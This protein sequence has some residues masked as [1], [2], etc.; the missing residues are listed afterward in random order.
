V[1]HAQVLPCRH[2]RAHPCIHPQVLSRFPSITSVAVSLAWNMYSF[3]C[4]RAQVRGEGG[5]WYRNPERRSTYLPRLMYILA[6]SNCP[7]YLI[8]IVH[9]GVCARRPAWP[10]SKL[11]RATSPRAFDSPFRQAH[12]IRKSLIVEDCI[13]PWTGACI[14]ATLWLGLP[15]QNED[16]SP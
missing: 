15:S 2:S 7:S 11:D 6:C 1:S 16:L 13:P 8:S 9:G 10:K 12:R 14:R 3:A 5:C 4:A